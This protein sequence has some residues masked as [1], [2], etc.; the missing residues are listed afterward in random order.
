MD[1]KALEELAKFGS[2]S[3]DS[4]DK[5]GGWVDDVFGRGFR[6]VGQAFAESMAGFRYRNRLRVLQKTQAAIDRA[7]LSGKT[8]PF[9][10]RLTGPMLDA[11][12]DESDENLQEAWAA[13]I[14]FSVD[15][16]NPSPDRLL[17]DII[18]RLEPADWPILRKLFQSEPVALQPEDIGADPG[19]MEA[20][21]DRFVTLGLFTYDDPRS[22]SLV[23][24]NHY[25]GAMVIKIGGANYHDSKVFD[26]LKAATE[27]AWRD[28]G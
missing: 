17:I 5:A 27:S 21:M 26:R 16:K 1:D 15:P 13:Y 8:R 19:E 24:A 4:V 7:K 10:D 28:A 25:A 18:R 23:N 3:L 6:E 14:A 11:I 22:T 9:A 20:S 12:A 2:R